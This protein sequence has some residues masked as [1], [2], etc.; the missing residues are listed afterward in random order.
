MANYKTANQLP[1][2][3]EVTE[4]TF[5]L[6][7]ENGSLKRV[8]GSNLGGKGGCCV[9]SVDKT[10]AAEP[11]AEGTSEDGTVYTCNMDYDELLASIQERTLTG[12]NVIIYADPE[13]QLGYVYQVSYGAGP[14]PSEVD[15]GSSGSPDI[16]IGWTNDNFRGVLIFSP[17]NTL[18]EFEPEPS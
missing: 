5:A 2:L 9:I 13:M 4:N 1:I 16:Y 12:F 14:E 7:E 3:E 6:V 15:S 18:T 8:S 11:S 10:N 17:D